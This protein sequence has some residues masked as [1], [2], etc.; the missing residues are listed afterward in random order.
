[1]QLIEPML[2]IFSAA[3]RRSPLAVVPGR[4]LSPADTRRTVTI[5]GEVIAG[6]LAEVTADAGTDPE[7]RRLAAGYPAPGPAPIEQAG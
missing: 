2:P 1:M 6:C 4:V 5:S 7:M 3:L